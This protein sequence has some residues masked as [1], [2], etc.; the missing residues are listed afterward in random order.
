[1]I[2]TH[3]AESAVKILTEVINLVDGFAGARIATGVTHDMLAERGAAADAA[4]LQ[5]VALEY[6]QWSE[7][8]GERWRS[9]TPAAAIDLRLPAE[10]TKKAA[11]PVI[12]T[13]A[14]EYLCLTPVPPKKPHH[15]NGGNNHNCAS[16]QSKR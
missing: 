14:R 8:Q 4:A 6:A 9:G 13:T 7:A 11:S 1:M 5:A 16:G 10:G 3:A 12:K 2:Q 15:G